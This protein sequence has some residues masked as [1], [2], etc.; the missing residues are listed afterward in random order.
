MFKILVFVFIIILILGLCFNKEHFIPGIPGISGMSGMSG[1]YN[2]IGKRFNVNTPMA[3]EIDYNYSDDSLQDVEYIND[4]NRI[5]NNNY[6]AVWLKPPVSYN[7]KNVNDLPLGINDYK[8]EITSYSYYIH[9]DTLK[10]L[11][12]EFNKKYTI[13]YIE[14]NKN[15]QSFGKLATISDDLGNEK[16]WKNKYFYDPNKNIPDK[17]ILSKFPNVDYILQFFIKKFNVIF[18]YNYNNSKYFRFYKPF[19]FYPFF[20]LKYKIVKYYTSKVSNI[21]IFEIRVCLLRQNDVNVIELYIIGYVDKVPILQNILLI[22]NEPVS[23]YLIHPGITKPNYYDIHNP[24]LKNTV[25]FENTEKIL[26]EREQYQKD[27]NEFSIQYQYRCFD[28]Q[29]D[30]LIIGT[31][32]KL[33]CE[34][35]VDWYGRIKNYGVW[36]RPCISDNECIY[37]KKNKNYD[38]EYG[39]C[40]PSGQCQMPVSTSKI[41][42]HFKKKNSKSKCY[43]C[44]TKKWRPFTELNECCEEQDKNNKNYNKKYD[45]LK[46]PD[47]A[48]DDDLNNRIN[49]DIKDKYKHGKFYIKHPDLFDTNKFKYY[50]K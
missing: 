13:S 42:Y 50:Y 47:Y 10:F 22:G 27:T 1:M 24:H 17:F 2:N 39:K 21:K 15:I 38:N 33:D 45:F 25:T 31:N 23:H 28:L 4:K 37:Y 19:K 36:D 46:G 43:N 14:F 40:L 29:K 41:G 44:D 30:G 34:N 6:N 26:K 49:Y 32:N 5:F 12:N 18:K 3:S 20:I 11:I 16:T 35:E 7:N 8:E 9:I 48:F